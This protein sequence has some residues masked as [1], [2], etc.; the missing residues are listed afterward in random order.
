MFFAIYK[1]TF[2][3]ILRNVTAW[4]VLALFVI[5][6]LRILLTPMNGRYSF[7]LNDMVWDTDDPGFVMDYSIYVQSIK[8]FVTGQLMTYAMPLFAIVTT[9]LML[10]RDY[11]DN[12]YE[13]EKAGGIKPSQY[14]L[15]RLAA[16]V[17]LNFIVATMVGFLFVHIYF[18]SRGALPYLGF[19]WWTYLADS[20][21]RLM[22][23]II[24]LAMPAILFYI[25]F[26]YCLGTLFKSGFAAGVLPIAYVIYTYIDVMIYGWVRNIYTDYLQPIPNKSSH[27]FHYYDSEWFESMLVLEDTNLTKAAICIAILVGVFVLYSTIAYLRTQKRDR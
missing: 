2:K 10:N 25:G 14:F 9:V 13:I 18:L 4:L 23:H 5:L 26:T 1:S 7:E 12:F 21:V 22:R 3:N 19:T 20:T 16:L 24:F 27:Y 8:G 17:T 11:G 6:A 15:G